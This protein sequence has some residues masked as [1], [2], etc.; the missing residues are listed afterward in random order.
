MHLSY[1][2]WKY[3]FRSYICK[4]DQCDKIQK[5]ELN[6]YWFIMNGTTIFFCLIWTTIFKIWL[7]FLKYFVTNIFLS[8]HHFFERFP[9]PKLFSNGVLKCL[10]LAEVWILSYLYAYITKIQEVGLIKLL[11]EDTFYLLSSPWLVPPFQQNFHLELAERKLVPN[12]PCFRIPSFV[13]KIYTI[14]KL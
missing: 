5:K 4:L 3:R 14:I 11:F 13:Y 10:L 9:K 6:K 2:S 12:V 1:G 7:I 8:D